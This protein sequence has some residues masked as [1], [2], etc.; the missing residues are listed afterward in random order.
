MG[1]RIMKTYARVAYGVVAE[2]I[3]PV[4][5]EDGHEV[6][7]ED[8]FTP[9]FVAQLGDVS[10]VAPAP[11]QRWTFDGSVCSVSANSSRDTRDQYKHP[12]WSAFHRGAGYRT[13]SGMPLTST[14]RPM[15]K[16]EWLKQWKQY[17]IAVNRVDVTQVSPAW[18]APPAAAA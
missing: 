1:I 2:I 6:A 16:I 10:D 7:I 4:V 17:R 12:G 8:R 11:Q 13:A 14:S 15:P 18:P 5:D 3:T 9:E